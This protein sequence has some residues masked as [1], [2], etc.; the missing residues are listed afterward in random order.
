MLNYQYFL[1]I[2]FKQAEFKASPG[3]KLGVYLYYFPLYS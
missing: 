2:Y 1:Q 3:L